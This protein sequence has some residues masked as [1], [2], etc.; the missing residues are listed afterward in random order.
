MRRNALLFLG[1]IPCICLAQDNDRSAAVVLFHQT[2]SQFAFDRDVAKAEAGFTRVVQMDHT[3]AKPYYNLAVL[4]EEKEDWEQAAQY[5]TK[6]LELSPDA[7]NK[8][9]IQEQI[10]QLAALK[11]NDK[12]LSKKDERRYFWLLEQ[13]KLALSEK[14]YQ[15]ARD[16]ASKAKDIDLGRWQAYSFL[17]QAE[18]GLG[19]YTEAA[20]SLDAAANRA[21][22]EQSKELLA[23]AAKANV[24]AHYE[25]LCQSAA[26][27]LSIADY[28][29]AADQLTA[30]WHLVPDHSKTGFDAVACAILAKDYETAKQIL[31]VLAK[32]PSESALAASM[33]AKVSI[34]LEVA[35]NQRD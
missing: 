26:S 9:D 14:R 32:T 10:K 25:T 22:Q 4:A 21:P 18:I 27:A 11:E 31:D 5:L 30:A 7:T 28:K 16:L 13:A 3:Y 8:K 15:A 2:L 33:L 12:D 34:L 1:T 29:S 24:E 19:A 23:V 20:A 6:Y 35:K 17:G